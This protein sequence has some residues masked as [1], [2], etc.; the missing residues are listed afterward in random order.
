M[1]SSGSGSA[2]RGP[3]NGGSL[4]QF[5]VGPGSATSAIRHWRLD[6]RQSACGEQ[7]RPFEE[8]REK[9]KAMFDGFEEKNIE[10]SEAMLRYALVE[11]VRHCFSCTAIRERT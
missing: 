10:V 9:G 11:R 1:V 6:S 2:R 8:S 5:N 7:G 3:I 4:R